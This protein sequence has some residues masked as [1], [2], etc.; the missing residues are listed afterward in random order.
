MQK[1]LESRYDEGTVGA[2]ILQMDTNNDKKE[3]IAYQFVSLFGDDFLSR[4]IGEVQEKITD[5]IESIPKK[6]AAYNRSYGRDTNI[7]LIGVPV[8]IFS[9]S[10]ILLITQLSVGAILGIAGACSLVVAI[11]AKAIAHHVAKT[12]YND[13]NSIVENGENP[14]INKRYKHLSYTLQ[15]LVS[16]N[17]NFRQFCEVANIHINDKQVASEDQL[18]E[19]ASL[20]NSLEQFSSDATSNEPPDL[21]GVVYL[22]EK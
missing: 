7:L 2:A 3:G 1:V 15:G 16:V 22:G 4:S 13:A 10:T 12:R 9:L 11:A 5:E 21:Q 8:V 18:N 6:I 19:G 20:F 17:Y 14:T